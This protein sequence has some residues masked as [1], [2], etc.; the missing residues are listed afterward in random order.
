MRIIAK[1]FPAFGLFALLSFTLVA[2]SPQTGEDEEVTSVPVLTPDSEGLRVA[3]WNVEHLAYPISAGCRPRSPQEINDLRAYAAQLDADIVALQEIGSIEALEQV[4][5]NSEWQLLLS[6]RPDSEPYECR[7]NGQLS[8]QQKVA[9][10]VRNGIDVTARLDL[11][12]L[13]LDNPG[14]RHGMQVSISSPLG[15][16]DLLNVH[17]KSGCFVDDFSRSDSE[18][19]QTFARQAPILDGWIENQERTGKPYFVLGDFNH[20]LS[21]PYNLLTMQVA[22]NSDGS[23]SSLINAT[24]G[25]IG[26]HPYYPAPIDH[27]LMGNLQD[28]ALVTS[29]QVHAFEDMDPD[30]MLSDHCAVSLTLEVGQLPLSNSVRWQTTSKEYRYLTTST[31]QRAADLLME[32][33]RPTDPWIVTMDIDETVLDNSQ[34]QVMLDRTGQSYSPDSWAEWVASEQAAL[35]PGVSAFIETVFDLG[36]RVGFITNRNRDQDHHT[37]QNLTALGLPITTDNTCLLGRSSADVSSVDGGAIVND[38]DLRRQQLQQGSAPCF[39][40]ENTRHNAFPASEIIMQ[41]GDNIEDFAGMTQESASIEAL[42]PANRTQFI[43]LPNPM[44]GSW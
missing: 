20:R 16:F 18:A 22:D 6:E 32:S 10:A 43:L 40:A 37:W 29:P 1:S 41:I 19:C 33:E 12:E 26:C 35:V 21:A 23:E 4:F 3:T 11:A 39:Q 34:Y 44:Y 5:P 25:L 24:A 42:L 27:I 14:L 17:M 9:F 2:C 28:P 13:G 38:K 8:T 7:D 15:A 30:A 36:G 31:Y